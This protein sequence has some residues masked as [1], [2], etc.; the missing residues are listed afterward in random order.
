MASKLFWGGKLLRVFVL[1]ILLSGGVAT[2]EG[3]FSTPR[4]A[5]THLSPDDYAV[6]TPDNAAQLTELA[7]FGYGELYGVQ[8]S[9][10][11]KMLAVMTDIGVW[12]YKNTD[13][14]TE[15]IV[16]RFP[17]L[18]MTDWAFSSDGQTLAIVG[19]EGLVHLWDIPSGTERAVLRGESMGRVFP[20]YDLDFSPDGQT[21]AVAGD[22]HLVR[23]WD[24][25]TGR[26]LSTLTG[27]ENSVLSVAFSPDGALL[28]SSDQDGAV[29]IWDVSTGSPS[30]TASLRADDAVWG[31]QW[32][33]GSERLFAHVGNSEGVMVW[34]WGTGDVL[35]NFDG[36]AGAMNADGS[37]LAY[38]DGD[39]TVHLWDLDTGAL[40]M[41]LDGH[42]SAVARLVFSPDGSRLASM[43]RETAI[44]WDVES[45]QQLASVGGHTRYAMYGL[46]FSSDGELLAVVNSLAF[47]QTVQILG[48]QSGD[49]RASMVFQGHPNGVERVQFAPE[50]NAFL[51]ISLDN[52][53]LWWDMETLSARALE[54]RGVWLLSPDGSLLALAQSDSGQVTLQDVE[55]G[56]ERAVFQTNDGEAVYS[57]VFSEDS[58]QLIAAGQ[59]SAL[60]YVWDVAS[61]ELLHTVDLRSTEAPV[62]PF[63]VGVQTPFWDEHSI[64]FSA[65][66]EWLAV[67][68]RGDS[69]FQLWDAAQGTARKLL[70]KRDGVVWGASFSSDGTLL[71]SA[72]IDGTVRLWDVA[73]GAEIAM[74]DTQSGKA[75]DLGFSPDGAMLRAWCEDD[76]I[77]L[78]T[79]PDGKALA[80][81]HSSAGALRGMAFDPAGALLVSTT[82]DGEM[83]VWEVRTGTLIANLEGAEQRGDHVAFSPDGKFIAQ[84]GAQLSLWGVPV[85]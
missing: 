1:L 85:R 75:C 16:L 77:H 79:L 18:D 56:E 59:D 70:D 2:V 44:L 40:R 55:T 25:R 32:S 47:P 8:W 64:A 74:M 22:D 60:V 45:G 14:S 12:L 23:L 50:G 3:G 30:P 11:G 4:Y 6:I 62:S 83:Q 36:A 58:A 39:G 57:M 15:Q 76:T 35:V 34:N 71:A 48:A 37:L 41:D 61:G 42:Q 10:D 38:D 69:G 82:D 51:S 68:S 72:G 65:D 52:T 28:A 33:S 53:A 7:A 29:I 84:G 5:G 27:H 26:E 24:V 31:L 54:S 80:V 19:W 73:N 13:F 43:D 67:A 9:P 81:L 21:L 63:L 17:P 20:V 46:G 78:W 49:A 66:G